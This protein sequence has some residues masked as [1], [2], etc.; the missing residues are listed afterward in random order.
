M[1]KST[2]PIPHSYLEH[3]RKLRELM[4]LR[5]DGSKGEQILQSRLQDEL[6]FLGNFGPTYL[7]G[8]SKADLSLFT[9]NGKISVNLKLKT[10][11][12]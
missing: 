11:R 12:R 3:A 8:G 1:Q 4:S 2:T 7:E 10:E 6:K 5:Y 9:K